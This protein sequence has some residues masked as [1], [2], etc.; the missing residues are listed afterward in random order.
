MLGWNTAWRRQE[1]IV[2]II[3]EAIAEHGEGPTLGEIVERAGLGSIGSVHYH[4]TQLEK[5]GVIVRE[6][7]QPRS[8]RLT[9]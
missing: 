8:I 5:K 9:C 3:R 4:L 1:Q 2:K 6:P 7:W